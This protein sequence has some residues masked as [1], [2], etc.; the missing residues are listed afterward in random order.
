MRA[1]VLTVSDGVAEGTRSDESGDVLASLLVGE[2]YQVERRVVPDDRP[3]QVLRG[4]DQLGIVYAP[5]RG[6]TEWI[7]SALARAGH[8]AVPYHAGLS[9]LRRRAALEDFLQDRMDVIVATCAA[10]SGTP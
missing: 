4:Q 8:R 1:A 6:A 3:D 2:G 10:D 5:T 7:A 9:K